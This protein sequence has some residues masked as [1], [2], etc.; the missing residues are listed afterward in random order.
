MQQSWHWQ[1]DPRL[2]VSWAHRQYRRWREYALL[3][4]CF[5]FA[6]AETWI[7]LERGK[8]GRMMDVMNCAADCVNDVWCDRSSGRR[9]DGMRQLYS[10][11]CHWLLSMFDCLL[12]CSFQQKVCP[13]HTFTDALPARE[14]SVAINIPPAV[15]HDGPCSSLD[16]G[17]CRLCTFSWGMYG[18]WM[19][20]RQF[21]MRLWGCKLMAET[22][23]WCTGGAP[24]VFDGSKKLA[25]ILTE[26]HC[27]LT[28]LITGICS[29]HLT[30]IKYDCT[31][32]MSHQ[33]QEGKET[34]KPWKHE[35]VQDG[36][37]AWIVQEKDS[38]EATSIQCSSGMFDMILYGNIFTMSMIH[39][40]VTFI[41]SHYY[42]AG[43]W[44]HF[45]VLSDCTCSQLGRLNKRWYEF[46]ICNV[47]R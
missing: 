8:V 47:K 37:K 32:G 12:L 6:V 25:H 24:V 13:P 40:H 4:C 1:R 22:L 18:H 30:G 21:W 28:C 19:K 17:S 2:F 44:I 23:R 39:F 10:T 29:I 3:D 45:Q 34:T 38:Q 33:C 36:R 31:S 27:F 14:N 26:T 5:D 35:K 46:S 9:L 16:C 15:D 42:L 7:L 20:R 41:L 11:S 43:E